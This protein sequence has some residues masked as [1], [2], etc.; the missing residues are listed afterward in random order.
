MLVWEIP[1]LACLS[2]KRWA[3]SSEGT[4]SSW[5]YH[6]NCIR[7]NK[8]GLLLKLINLLAF[9][10]QGFR[11]WGFPSSIY[12]LSDGRAVAWKAAQSS[13]KLHLFLPTAWA[14]FGAM[15]FVAF[16]PWQIFHPS[17]PFL[18]Q[19]LTVFLNFFF[20]SSRPGLVWL[21]PIRSESNLPSLPLC[22]PFW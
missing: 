4:S 16:Y 21:H 10:N 1:G 19:A 12:F 2:L 18:D 6:K 5:L 15:V 22:L 17:F 20:R 8:P 14:D 3:N 11:I 13:R 7:W 9:Q